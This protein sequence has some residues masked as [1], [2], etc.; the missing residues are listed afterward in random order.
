MAIMCDKA[1]DKGYFFILMMKSTMFSFFLF[2]CFFVLICT[3]DPDNDTT[4][5]LNGH[6]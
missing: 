5:T 2:F 6:Q 1:F 3:S 4:G